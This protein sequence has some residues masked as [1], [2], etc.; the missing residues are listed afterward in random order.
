MR[1]FPGYRVRKK[2]S[3]RAVRPSEQVP[4]ILTLGCTELRRRDRNDTDN[5]SSRSGCRG[6]T[7][8]RCEAPKGDCD[9][10]R[11]VFPNSF[12]HHVEDFSPSHIFIVIPTACGEASQPRHGRGS[13]PPGGV[14]GSDRTGFEG[15]D[16]SF[17]STGTIPCGRELGFGLGIR[18]RN[19]LAFT[20]KGM[21]WSE[22]MQYFS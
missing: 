19:R 14:G 11:E 15:V 1:N 8:W 17:T 7:I 9:E 12:P 5:R 22:T 6:E 13:R 4:L 3:P 20:P 18:G 10:R 2:G 21:S 16:R